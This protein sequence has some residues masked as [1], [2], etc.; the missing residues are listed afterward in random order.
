M[1]TSRLQTGPRRNEHEIDRGRR[2]DTRAV[3][4]ETMTLQDDTVAGRGHGHVR[5]AR[6]PQE[7]KI[8]T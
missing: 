7:Q 4:I 6:R 3:A 2:G 5:H 8:Q 1:G